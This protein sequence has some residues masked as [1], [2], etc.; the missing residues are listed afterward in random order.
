MAGASPIRRGRGWWLAGLAVLLLGAIVTALWLARK[1]VAEHFIDDA[2]AARG[3]AARYEIARIG[4]RTQRLTNVRIGDPAHP[5]LLADWIEVDTSLWFSGATLS[6]IRVGSCPAAR[7]A[8]RRD[9]LVRRARPAAARPLGQAVRASRIDA[10]IADARIALAT[11]YGPI[12]LHVVGGGRLDSGFA[13]TLDARAARLDRDGCRL[14][15]VA[16]R[17]QVQVRIG[18]TALAG[19]L[20]LGRGACGGARESVARARSRGDAAPTLDHGRRRGLRSRRSHVGGAR[21]RA[22]SG[23]VAFTGSAARGRGQRRLA[24]GRCCG[25]GRSPRCG[26]RWRGA[27][28]MARAASRSMAVHARAARAS[29]AMAR[30]AR[31]M[32]E[33]GRGNADR[34]DRRA[35][36]RRAARGG[37]GGRSRRAFLGGRRCRRPAGHVSRLAIRRRLGR[38]CD[39]RRRWRARYR[40]PQ[41]LRIDSNVTLGAAAC[42]CADRD[43]GRPAPVLR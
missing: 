22:L 1:P 20:T 39:A 2:L 4:L 36:G 16:A 25:G 17:L 30:A 35:S 29:A 33:R 5:D 40:W 24:L 43:C 38:A 34:P 10:R 21:L 9:G 27:I 3:I 41:G 19:P 13:G 23:P 42:R 11:P 31:S 14:D 37:S 15:A 6:A 7:A 18:Q 26:P 8:C 28:A 32:A 12:A